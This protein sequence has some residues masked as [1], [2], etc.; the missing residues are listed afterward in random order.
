MQLKLED[1]L[2]AAENV[3][4]ICRKWE[5]PIVACHWRGTYNDYD[6]TDC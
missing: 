5:L 4:M 2:F 3:Y 1:L 6:I